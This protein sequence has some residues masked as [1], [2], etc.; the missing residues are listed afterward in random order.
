MDQTPLRYPVTTEIDGKTYKGNYWIAG[1]ILTVSTGKVTVFLE[2]DADIGRKA[3]I[4][5]LD[6]SGQ[7]VH[8]LPTTLGQ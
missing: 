1:K 8:S 6:S 7:V 4:V 2:N 3:E 5:L